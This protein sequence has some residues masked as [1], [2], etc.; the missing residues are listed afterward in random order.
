MFIMK[1]I[2]VCGIL[3]ACL[4][5][6]FA[7][8]KMQSTEK[9]MR[10]QLLENDVSVVVPVLEEKETKYFVLPL[11]IFLLVEGYT[12]KKLCEESNI[13]VFPDLSKV[14]ARYLY[15]PPSLP[16]TPLRPSLYRRCLVAYKEILCCG[17]TIFLL[18]G[19]TGICVFVFPPLNSS[20][21]EVPFS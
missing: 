15:E 11:R 18:V 1:T 5:F 6:S 13:K 20:E 17:C 16:I 12:R 21:G 19:L 8:N 7:V 3:F 10:L 14:I 2:K 4:F 9:E